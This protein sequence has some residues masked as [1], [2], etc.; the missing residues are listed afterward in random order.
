MKPTHAYA[1]L[2]QLQ[3]PVFTTREAAALWHSE[4]TIA[5]RR[6]GT[7]EKAGLLLRIQRGLW[8]LDPDIEPRV[9]G[10]YLT[11]PLPSYISLFS[12]LAE[13]GLIEQ[14][15]RQIS[16]VSLGRPRRIQTSLGVFVVHQL[17]PELFGGFEGDGRG[18]FVARPEKALFDLV[19]VRAA[20]GTRAYLPELSLPKDFK[21][22]ELDRWIERIENQRLRTIVS[23]R[24]R[25]LLRG[26]F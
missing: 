10:P 13:H 23:R 1:E 6:L 3:R 22:G 18:G 8:A 5:S 26:A 24:L 15:P 25:E 14:I 17:S 9:V 7:L 20:G 12:A 11:A 4:Q 19:Y 16:L 21:R 2:R